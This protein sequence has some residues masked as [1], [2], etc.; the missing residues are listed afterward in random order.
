MGTSSPFLTTSRPPRQQVPTVGRL[1][2]LGCTGPA[3]V[4]LVLSVSVGVASPFTG[5]LR[6][7]PNI[8]P[9]SL[10]SPGVSAGL[11]DV[12]DLVPFRLSLL[13]PGGPGPQT[14]VGAEVTEHWP[15]REGTHWGARVPLGAGRHPVWL[16]LRAEALGPCTGHASPSQGTGRRRWAGTLGL[17]QGLCCWAGFRS[18]PWAGVGMWEEVLGSALFTC[19]GPGGRPSS[20]LGPI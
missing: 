16:A 5:G 6:T 1:C 15:F 19:T 7:P 2:P 12:T 18:C 9:Q 13:A 10:W 14:E 20:V 17:L 11:R 3:R 8:A 4:A